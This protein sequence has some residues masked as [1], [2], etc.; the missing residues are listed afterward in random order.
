LSWVSFPDEQDAVFQFGPKLTVTQIHGGSGFSVVPD[1]CRIDVDIRLT[2]SFG[3]DRA[4]NLMEEV[5]SEIDREFP[6]VGEP[7]AEYL[8][9]EDLIDLA[10]RTRFVGEVWREFVRGERKGTKPLIRTAPG[11]LPGSRQAKSLA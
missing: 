8:D 3:A 4:L 5:C 6:S 11:V 1:S 7:E 10:T 2:P 9:V